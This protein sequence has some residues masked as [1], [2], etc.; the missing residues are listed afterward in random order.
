MSERVSTISRMPRFRSPV[1][2]LAHFD[3][4]LP[5]VFP[6]RMSIARCMSDVLQFS[7]C[8]AIPCEMQRFRN[9]SLFESGDSKSGHCQ[10]TSLESLLIENLFQS[11][12]LSPLS[13]RNQLIQCAI[14]LQAIRSPRNDLDVSF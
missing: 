11:L 4:T 5:P 13:Q 12:R 8:H 9:P 10:L 6:A 2:N 14:A 3:E 1:V 7:C